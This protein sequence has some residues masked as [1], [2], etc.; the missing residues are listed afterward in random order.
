MKIVHIIDTL[1]MG[2]AENVLIGLTAGQKQLGHEVTVIPLVCDNKTPVRE[3]IELN[4]VT[5]IPLK[6][7]GTVYNPAFIFK[8]AKHIRNYDIIN[9]HLFPAFYWAAFAKLFSFCRVPMVYTEH[10]TNNKRRNNKVLHT[11]DKFV[12]KFGYKMIIACAEK[13][14]E[15]YNGAFPSIKHTCYINNGVET[16]LY[17]EAHPYKKSELL[18]ISEDSFVIT[19]VARFMTMK[20]QDT[21]VEALK[22]LPPNFHAVFV[23]GNKEDEGLQRVKRI[24]EGEGVEQRVHFLYIRPDVPQILKT[25]DI[26][27]MASDYEGLSLSSIEGMAAG[28]PFISTDVNG[29][30]EIVGGAGLLFENKNPQALAHLIN[31]LATDKEYYSEIAERCSLRA[32]VFDVKRMVELYL[33]VYN[34][35]LN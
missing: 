16:S 14:L 19:M 1:S 33:D 35:V 7:R 23:G 4:K 21:I 25:S 22:E 13:V 3:K 8:L 18:G 15:T 11:V 28:K 6:E 20:R 10:S 31:K 29:L 9:V 30:R 5:V 27:I 24:A 34:K 2:G 12:Y 26:V 32:S 17:R